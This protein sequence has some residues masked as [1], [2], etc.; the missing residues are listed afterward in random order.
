MEL[1][2]V[3]PGLIAFITGLLAKIIYDIWVERRKKKAI[4]YSKKVIGSFSMNLLSENIRK[5]TQVLFDNSNI[6]SVQI[7]KVS[8]E[9]D[10][11]SS[12][13]NQAFTVRFGEKATILGTPITDSS[14]EDLRYIK[15]VQGDG[16]NSYRFTVNLLQTKRKLSWDFTVINNDQGTIKIEPGI[17]SQKEDFSD[18]DLDVAFALSEEKAAN[19]LISQLKNTLIILSVFI[20]SAILILPVS[21]LF[22]EKY[23]TILALIMVGLLYPLVN[24]ITKLIALFLENQRT[25]AELA[26]IT[27]IS[28]NGN[29]SASK[30]SQIFL[31]Q[32]TSHNSVRIDVPP[33]MALPKQNGGEIVEGSIVPDPLLYAGGEN[34]ENP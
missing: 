29:V 2:D 30:D 31:S 25:K 28:I 7:I 9:N 21:V 10:G 11:G 1:K 5:R 34:Q 13:R 19:D 32:G 23:S 20:G 24:S 33:E 6:D 14:S 18:T 15:A 17:N 4:L 27:S 8:I 12:V 26:N 22:D 3:I 16:P